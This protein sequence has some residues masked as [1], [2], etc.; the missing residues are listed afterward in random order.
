ML[1]NKEINGERIGDEEIKAHL[2]FS[3]SDL[4][5]NSL[6]PYL[7]TDLFRI[8]KIIG[9]IYQSAQTHYNTSGYSPDLNSA[10][11]LDQLVHKIQAAHVFLAYLEF[12][13][14]NDLSHSN[15]GRKQLIGTD[16][17]TAWEWQIEADNRALL[18]K[19]YNALDALLY[20]LELSATLTGFETW[21]NSDERKRL[22]GNF[23]YTVDQFDDLFPIDKSQR[24]FMLIRPF[25]AEIETENIESVI[26]TSRFE[27]ITEKI[28]NDQALTPEEM[29]I[30]TLAS[31]A[32][33]YF[34]IESAM[35]KLADEEMPETILRTYLPDAANRK[36]SNELKRD[37]R[38]VYQNEAAKHLRKLQQFILQ[39]DAVESEPVFTEINSP[40]NKFF[41]A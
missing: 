23:I 36:K 12:A 25:M 8:R 24:F 30:R 18:R 6:Q 37:Q 2:G 27:T 38:Q 39:L 10:V 32:I 22:R 17:K 16:E 19:G 20:F 35:Y 5:F 28:K 9:G 11:V 34:T 33:A 4:E 31:R 15:S 7:L 29:K 14:N 40:D 41:Q 1:F 21:K 13:K 26:G 3:F